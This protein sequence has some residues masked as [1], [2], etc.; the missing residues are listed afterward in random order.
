[1]FLRATRERKTARRLPAC[2]SAPNDVLDSTEA[3]SDKSAA[4]S[5]VGG[6]ATNTRNGPT[7]TRWISAASYLLDACHSTPSH[8]LSRFVSQMYGRF[9]YALSA[10]APGENSPRGASTIGRFGI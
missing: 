9:L 3:T 1:F 4:I 6:E 5:I 8:S 2:L 10:I 7:S